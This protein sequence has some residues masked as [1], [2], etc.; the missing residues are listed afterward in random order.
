MKRKNHLGELLS[1][2]PEPLHWT[3]HNL[4]AHPLGELTYLT[5]VLLDKTFNRGKR[6]YHFQN[7]IHD[8]TIP[9]H[10]KGEG[11]G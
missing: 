7:W 1:K 6:L 4:V 3:A 2:L 11:R 10:R 9:E 5:S 8:I